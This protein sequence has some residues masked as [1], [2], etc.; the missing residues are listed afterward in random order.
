MYVVKDHIINKKGADLNMYDLNALTKA[1]KH[2]TTMTRHDNSKQSLSRSKKTLKKTDNTTKPHIH[3]KRPLTDK[4]TFSAPFQ[5]PKKT[6]QP[7]T[8]TPHDTISHDTVYNE[9][10]FFVIKSVDS[11]GGERYEL[12]LKRNLSC[13]SA[14]DTLSGLCD[15]VTTM[16][17]KHGHCLSGLKEYLDSADIVVSHSMTPPP[18]V[19]ERRKSKVNNDYDNDLMDAIKRSESKVATKKTKLRRKSA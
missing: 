15:C 6:I 7:K 16:T 4:K 8:T 13:I 9:L 17:D 18:T 12:I 14:Q 5:T 3:N 11:L 19:V 1:A 2:K 10:P